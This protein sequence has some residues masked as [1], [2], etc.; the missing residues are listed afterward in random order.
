MI[1]KT[2]FVFFKNFF[3]FFSLATRGTP[4]AQGSRLQANLG[5]GIHHFG[6]W[7]LNQKIEKAQGRKDTSTPQAMGK[8]RTFYITKQG[9]RIWTRRAALVVVGKQTSLR[10][11]GDFP[12][13]D[14]YTAGQPRE[15]IKKP[16]AL[17]SA[18]YWWSGT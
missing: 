14:T 8:G 15:I 2:S 4:A 16:W 17:N 6:L 12:F 5:D 7:R 1:A 11:G 3:F 13:H 9:G 10:R 18:I